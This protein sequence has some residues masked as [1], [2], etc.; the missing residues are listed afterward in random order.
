MGSRPWTPA[1]GAAPSNPKIMLAQPHSSEHMPLVLHE[2]SC[3]H[4]GMRAYHRAPVPPPFEG[5][6]GGAKLPPS[7]GAGAEPAASRFA[8]HHLSGGAGAAPTAIQFLST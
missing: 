7:G 1:M 5:G 6:L 3:N 4:T 8:R 2:S